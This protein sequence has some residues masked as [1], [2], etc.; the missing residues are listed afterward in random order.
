M[1]K[2]TKYEFRKNL[3]SIIIVFLIL[4]AAQIY[5]TVSCIFKEPDHAGLAAAMLI[6]FSFISFLIVI[7]FGISTYNKELNSNSSYLIFMT[8]NSS[9]KIILS[10]LFY[11]FIFGCTLALV[12]VILSYIDV[13]ML[14]GLDGS[15]LDYLELI[16]MLI[17][18][19][20]IDYMSIVFSIITGLVSIIVS[21][22][23]IIALSYF[24]ITLTSTMLQNKKFKNFISLIVFVVIGWLTTL[25]SNKLPLIYD[26]PQTT[27]QAIVT[28][29]PSIIFSL[30]VGAGCVWISAILLDKRVSL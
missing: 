20:G 1:L 18:N 21:I 10:K 13:K 3:T 29:L 28:L 27:V 23:C 16:K 26:N 30:F 8:P 9:F 15:P 25:I 4:A 6:T 24:A 12:L 22:F 11:T 14:A 2:L 17:T 7:I 5:F 19:M